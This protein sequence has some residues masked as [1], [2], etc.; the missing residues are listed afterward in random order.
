MKTLVSKKSFFNAALLVLLASN[1]A[2]HAALPSL[3]GALEVPNKRQVAIETLSEFRKFLR[4]SDKKKM[5]GND[6]RYILEELNSVTATSG[7]LFGK[8]PFAKELHGITY[9]FKDDKIKNA[10]YQT[11]KKVFDTVVRIH[12]RMASKTV[13]FGSILTKLLDQLKN[14]KK[15]LRST[16]TTMHREI[17]KAIAETKKMK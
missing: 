13:A 14:T 17:D 15:R 8:K 9:K 12:D 2:M 10:I 4:T 16:D 1:A 6:L 3:K 7:K 11:T 5:K